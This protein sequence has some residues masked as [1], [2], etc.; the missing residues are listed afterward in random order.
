MRVQSAVT[1]NMAWWWVKDLFPAR[2]IQLRL[3]SNK[4]FGKMVILPISYLLCEKNR[5]WHIEQKNLKCYMLPGG[6]DFKSPSRKDSMRAFDE[7]DFLTLKLNGQAST[8]VKCNDSQSL[9]HRAF[10]LERGS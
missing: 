7:T 6:A 9:G 4:M 2:Y 5:P 8:L 10:R 3:P 1:P